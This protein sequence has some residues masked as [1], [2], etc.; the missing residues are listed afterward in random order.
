MHTGLDVCSFDAV[1]V[2]ML[3]DCCFFVYSS[4]D[5]ELPMQSMHIATNVV[6]YRSG[7]MYSIQHYVIKFA[8]DLRQ[9]GGFIRVLRFPPPIKL[10]A[11]I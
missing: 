6:E 8:I 2:Y 1:D 4:L 9:D 5:L 10:N 11:T 7:D 3:V